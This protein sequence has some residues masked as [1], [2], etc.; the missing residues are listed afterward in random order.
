[1]K[2]E[3]FMKSPRPASDD[4]GREEQLELVNEPGRERP[5]GK[6]RAAH[7]EVASSRLLQNPNLP[8]I[9]MSLDSGPR[10]RRRLQRPGVDDLLRRLPDH[11][12]V[13]HGGR[14]LRERIRVFPRGHHVIDPSPIQGSAHAALDVVDETVYF[15]VRGGPVEVAAPI[16]HVAVER[17][18]SRVDQ[19][20][21]G[22][23][24]DRFPW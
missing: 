1:M 5:R 7:A 6:V 20:S 19:L 12:E 13:Q 11:R 8:G 18:D 14:L 3:T 17:R 22:S 4:D 23:Y 2:T 9:E 10:G 16:C 15:L 21:H 24:P